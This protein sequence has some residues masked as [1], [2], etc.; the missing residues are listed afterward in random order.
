MQTRVDKGE[1]LKYKQTMRFR[2]NAK[3]GRRS[4]GWPSCFLDPRILSVVVGL[5]VLLLPG[6]SRNGGGIETV[7]AVYGTST[8]FA[9]VSLRVR[10]LLNAELEFQ[11]SPNVLQADPL[12]GYNKALVIVYVVRGQ[13]RIF[14]AGEGDTVSAATLLST[15]P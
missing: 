9:D 2:I 12:P 13:R 11:V 10:K 3:D 5:A 7:S 8:N 1:R 14:T 15:R 4:V 6:C